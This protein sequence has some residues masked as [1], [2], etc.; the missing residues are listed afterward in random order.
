MGW[1]TFHE[2]RTAKQYFLDELG[3]EKHIEVVDIAIVSF[4]TAYI[5]V[6][7]LQKGYIYCAVFMLHRAPKSYYN[8]GYKDMT[9][10]AGPAVVDCPKRII[11]KLTPIDEIVK[12]DSE[13]GENSIK[14]ARDWRQEVL[15]NANIKKA[16]NNSLQKGG[17][18][19][20]SE[21]LL[22]NSGNYFQYF[23][24]KGG[25]LYAISDFDTEYEQEFPVRIIGWKN[26]DF[27]IVEREN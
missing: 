16:R 25:R 27:E 12:L 26:I 4:R 18:L 2:T 5:A 3:K 19:K 23:K 7:D 20:T 14:W 1:L 15:D 8:F 24:K 10:F 13:L 9:E 11:D 6:K 22:F 21:P 17:I